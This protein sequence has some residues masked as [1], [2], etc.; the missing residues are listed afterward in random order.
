MNRTEFAQALKALTPAQQSR[1]KEL[2]KGIKE[3]GGKNAY[4]RALSY[5]LEG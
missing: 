1:A 3:Q 4:E 2:A 5:V